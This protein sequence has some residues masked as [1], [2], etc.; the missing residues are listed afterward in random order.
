[1]RD[2]E[3]ERER[4]WERRRERESEFFTYRVSQKNATLLI[5]NISKM[6]QPNELSF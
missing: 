5:L 1:M 6:V 3:Q 2:S 4:E